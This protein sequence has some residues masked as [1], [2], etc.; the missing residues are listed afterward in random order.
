MRE[1]TRDIDSG[2]STSARGLNSPP[3]KHGGLVQRLLLA[4]QFL[5]AMLGA[6]PLP[7]SI[8]HFRLDVAL[9]E[10]LDRPL[11]PLVGFPQRLQISVAGADQLLPVVVGGGEDR[12]GEPVLLRLGAKAVVKLQPMLDLFHPCFLLLQP[13]LAL[14]QLDAR[15]LFELPAETQ[16]RIERKA[17]SSHGR[18]SP[19]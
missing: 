7:Q 18:L 17:E 1:R 19:R 15:L 10:R 11:D 13:A 16:G 9:L 5:F 6:A 14:P 4:L 3:A 8:E 2:M 12:S